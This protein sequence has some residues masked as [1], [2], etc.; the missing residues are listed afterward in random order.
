VLEESGHIDEALVEAEAALGLGVQ[1]GDRHREAALHDHV[2]DLLH[3]AG[4]DSEAMEHLKA[5]AAAFAEVDD[6]SV[7]P[8]VWKLVA[9]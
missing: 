1:H 3:L 9:W 8:D 2:A 7:R 5:A 4:R 6:A